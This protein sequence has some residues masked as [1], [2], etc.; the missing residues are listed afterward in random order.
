MKS[1]DKLENEMTKKV[2]YQLITGNFN[3]IYK[4]TDNIVLNSCK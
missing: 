2:H 1:K 4:K 3:K